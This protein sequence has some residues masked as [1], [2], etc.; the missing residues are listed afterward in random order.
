MTYWLDAPF[1]SD[2]QQPAGAATRSP[3]C[4]HASFSA[5]VGWIAQRASGWFD[6]REQAD[7]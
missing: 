1:T 5:S 2:K 4:V 3:E 7:R 6:T